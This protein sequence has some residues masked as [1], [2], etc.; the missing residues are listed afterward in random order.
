[1]KAK[2]IA[3]QPTNRAVLKQ[4]HSISCCP[5]IWC[6]FHTLLCG[7]GPLLGDEQSIFRVQCT[8]F[9]KKWARVTKATMRIQHKPGDA[10]QIDWAG[11]TIHSAQNHIH[12]INAVFIFLSYNSYNFSH[13]MHIHPTSPVYSGY[14][15]SFP[16]QYSV[17]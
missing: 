7:N 15:R 16:L 2:K 3:G 10:L 8:R 13:S 1:M 17:S 4:N 14:F 12:G 11:D 9:L 5:A 6:V